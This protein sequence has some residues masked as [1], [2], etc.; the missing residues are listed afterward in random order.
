MESMTTQSPV[1]VTGVD[2]GGLS[3]QIPLQDKGFDFY[4]CP[5]KSV[6]LF[7]LYLSEFFLV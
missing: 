3:M 4:L 2:A 6:G 7:L 1:E 5:F